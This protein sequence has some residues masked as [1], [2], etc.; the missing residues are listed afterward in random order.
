[1][2]RTEGIEARPHPPSLRPRGNLL[3]RLA[4]SL[5]RAAMTLMGVPALRCRRCGTHMEEVDSRVTHVDAFV[6]IS[7]HYWRCP[8]CG[9]FGQSDQMVQM[10]D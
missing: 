7:T 4:T 10:L 8:E 2:L 5:G 6:A 3:A 1:M 9:A